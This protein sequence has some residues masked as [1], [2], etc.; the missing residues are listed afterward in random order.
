MQ[1]NRGENMVMTADKRRF[2]EKLKLE[3]RNKILIKIPD[4]TDKEF[5]ELY[6]RNYCVEA[7]EADFQQH[8]YY[9]KYKYDQLLDEKLSIKVVD[10]VHQ[11]ILDL[12]KIH[13]KEIA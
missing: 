11:M 7:I 1:K 10:V 8:S 13:G 4:L 6:E 3:S 12:R 2:M 9:D 5:E